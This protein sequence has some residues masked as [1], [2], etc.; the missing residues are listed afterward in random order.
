[1]NSRLLYTCLL[2]DMKSPE[3][4]SE[5]IRPIEGEWLLV[6]E[7]A[8]YAKMCRALVYVHIEQ[9]HFKSFVRKT[10]PWSKSG[11]RLISRSSIDAFLQRQA[12]EAG[13]L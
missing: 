9:G 12:Q 7:A 3:L 2:D 4:N 10:H 13:A 5:T 8:R 11:R 6:P 1:M